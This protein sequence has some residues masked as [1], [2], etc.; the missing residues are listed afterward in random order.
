MTSESSMKPKKLVICACRKY[1]KLPQD[2]LDE[3]VKAAASEGSIVKVIFP[4]WANCI[5]KAIF[6]I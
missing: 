2:V 6:I 4:I 1:R 5:I 3:A